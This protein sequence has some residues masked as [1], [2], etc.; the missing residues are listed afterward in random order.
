MIAKKHTLIVI[1][2]GIVV[3]FLV[4]LLFYI[5]DI[6]FG[7]VKPISVTVLAHVVESIF[8][9]GVTKEDFIVA[10]QKDFNQ[11][12]A[13]YGINFVVL[14]TD[15]N[16]KAVVSSRVEQLENQFNV[17]TAR[18]AAKTEI[19][20]F[21]AGHSNELGDTAYLPEHVKNAMLKYEN[22]RA[23]FEAAL[24]NTANLGNLEPGSV[25]IVAEIFPPPAVMQ[26]KSS[27]GTIDFNDPAFDDI[28]LSY[29]DTIRR[30]LMLQH[31]V[32]IAK[33]ELGHQFGI[34]DNKLDIRDAMRQTINIRAGEHIMRDKG[35]VHF[36]KDDLQRMVPALKKWTDVSMNNTQP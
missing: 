3:A 24:A 9:P 14:L 7:T 8:L 23:L 33:R 26:M 11:E 36:N 34:A 29:D 4:Y 12:F 15:T 35:S 1:F 6:R 22:A 19:A 25:G 21:L 18:L 32:N 10:L 16:F 31:M 28:R 5:K 20:T 13:D 30:G 2:L 17:E 27:D